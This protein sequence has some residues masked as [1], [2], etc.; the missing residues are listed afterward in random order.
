ME[1]A[2]GISR[3]GAAAW[4]V[5]TLAICAA[6]ST[7]ELHYSSRFL[8]PYRQNDFHVYLVAADL[9]HAHESDRLYDD[10]GSGAPPMLRWA[11]DQQCDGSDGAQPG[12]SKDAAV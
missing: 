8:A 2:G 9:V 6:V 1:L 5:A 3:R 10:S 12:T 4:L 7:C 11:S